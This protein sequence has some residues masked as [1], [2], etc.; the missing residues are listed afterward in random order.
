MFN[1][2]AV[3]VAY[4]PVKDNLSSALSLLLAQDV[5]EIYVMDNSESDLLCS[6]DFCDHRIRV[7]SMN[8][9]K[10]IA[11]AQSL[12]MHFAFNKGA[13]FILQMDQDSV[14]DENMLRNLLLC[15]RKA[16]S[17]GYT[18]GIV[19][20]QDYD[21]K[22]GRKHKKIKF[23]PERSRDEKDCYIV[24]SILS[25]G[26]LVSKI[27]YDSVGGMENRL[28]IDVVDFEYCWRMKKYGYYTVKSKNAIIYHNLGERRADLLG[29]FSVGVPTPSRHYYAYR[30]ILCLF[31]RSYV[32][33]QWKVKAFVKLILKFLFYPVFLDRG[34]E[35]LKYMIHGVKAAA[36]GK[37]GK[38]DI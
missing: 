23:I 5:R 32:P 6:D 7:Y 1:V 26:S 22:L 16:S 38:C 13:D 24:S 30:N 17:L 25:S 12:G 4:H 19:G 8:G 15:Y 36:S 29:V 14:P 20:A 3:V 28:F 33:I 18:V 27:A 2:S 11:A 35:R 10:G 34:S 9:N 31:S 37:Y 21:E